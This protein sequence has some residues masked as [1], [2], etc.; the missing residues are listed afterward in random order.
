MTNNSNAT[1]FITDVCGTLVYDDTTLGLLKQHFSQQQ[2]HHSLKRWQ[3]SIKE[4]LK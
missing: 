2:F 3:Q 4:I 1:L